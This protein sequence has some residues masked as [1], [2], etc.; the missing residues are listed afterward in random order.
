MG[1]PVIDGE[2]SRSHLEARIGS[3]LIRVLEFAN[4]HLGMDAAFVTESSNQGQ[5]YRSA[6]GDT[7]S[8]GIASGKP[9]VS[10]CDL[11]LAGHI[12]HAIPAAFAD[13]RVRDLAVTVRGRIGA[14]IGVPIVLADGTI[15]GSLACVSHDAHVLGERDVRFMELLAGLVAPEVEGAREHDEARAAIS[16]L[17]DTEDMEVALQPVFDV[18]DG[19]CLGVE[20]LARFPAAYGATEA[21]FES[22]HSV[23]LGGA[24]ERLA[25]GRAIALLPQLPPNQFLAVNLTPHVAYELAGLGDSYAGFMSH[26][27]LE[28]TEH[29]AVDSYAE[30]R[31]ALRPMRDLGLRLAIDDAGAGYASLKHVIELEPDIIKVDRSIIDGLAAD[32]AR[33]SVVSAFVLLAL[34]LG[35][36]VIAEGIE[37]PEDLEA[38]RDLGVDAAQGYLFARPT[39]DLS[40]LVSWQSAG[41]R[42]SQAMGVDASLLVS[43]QQPPDDRNRAR[44]ALL[45]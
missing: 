1:T 5:V 19:H 44:A 21:V 7:H 37:T 16:M 11:M 13:S 15:F 32:R 34:E 43:P 27:V 10:Y 6:H 30:L 14:Y 31:E 41:S 9:S 33:R 42:T 38:V 40:A 25:L 36:T 23:G 39:T 3:Q 35:A 26:L 8:F 28:I 22:A 24:L 45:S 2:A 4:Q 20:A 18:H 12:P 17:I 29:A